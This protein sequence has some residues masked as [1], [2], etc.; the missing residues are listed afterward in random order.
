MPAGYQSGIRAVSAREDDW[1]RRRKKK[2]KTR[3][4]NSFD[5]SIADGLESDPT[6]YASHTFPA[7]SSI[8]ISPWRSEA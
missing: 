2:E 7:E 3:K 6:L 5:S 8:S 1:K 4:K